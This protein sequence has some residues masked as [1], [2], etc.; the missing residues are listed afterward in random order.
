MYKRNVILI[1]PSGKDSQPYLT[2]KMYHNFACFD[3]I[4]DSKQRFAHLCKY[5]GI[6]G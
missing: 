3:A 2:I 1:S 5:I 6:T 4:N